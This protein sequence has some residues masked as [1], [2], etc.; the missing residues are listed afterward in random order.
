MFTKIL[1][2][3]LIAASLAASMAAFSTSAD[4]QPHR[5]HRWHRWHGGRVWMMPPPAQT[6]CVWRKTWRH[7]HRVRVRVCRRVYW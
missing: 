5:W 3:G 7:H 6:Y 2:G 4:A 1:T